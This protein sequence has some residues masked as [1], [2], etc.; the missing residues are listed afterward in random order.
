MDS[1]EHNSEELEVA[2]SDSGATAT[3][4]LGG[5]TMSQT[6]E[7]EPTSLIEEANGKEHGSRKT[8]DLVMPPPVSTSTRAYVATRP[9]SMS[10]G[11][12]TSSPRKTSNG[13]T[14][15]PKKWVVN[16]PP[17]LAGFSSSPSAQSRLSER[18]STRFDSAVLAQLNFGPAIRNEGQ[19]LQGGLAPQKEAENELETTSSPRI[20]LTSSDNELEDTTNG[21]E[22]AQ[23]P[24]PTEQDRELSEPIL[25]DVSTLSTAS[26]T[27]LDGSIQ[28]E[29]LLSP[30]SKPEVPAKSAALLERRKEMQ[31]NKPSSEVSTPTGSLSPSGHKHAP[32]PVPRRKSGYFEKGNFREPG[33]H[34]ES[35][36]SN[37]SADTDPDSTTDRVT[38]NR[39]HRIIELA[40]SEA[41]YVRSLK[42]LIERFLVPM[43]DSLA[44]DS[45]LISAEGSKLICSNIEM[46]YKIH[47]PFA[48]EISKLE[49]DW[50]KDSELGPLMLGLA[51]Y[52]RIYST[53]I[54]KYNKAM[55]VFLEAMKHKS[56]RRFISEGLAGPGAEL[57]DWP[58]YYIQPVQ[59][60]PKYLIILSETLKETPESHPDH[61]KL[62][63]ALDTL[64]SLALVR[65]LAFYQ[66]IL[67]KY[68]ANILLVSSF[69]MLFLSHVQPEN[70][71]LVVEMDYLLGAGIF[72]FFS[73]L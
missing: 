56:F 5:D 38:Q 32:P 53:Y 11:A 2:G 51:P 40:R 39:K 42:Y 70:A 18:L 16:V 49:K 28:S 36:V 23:P 25:R 54:T 9:V 24:T 64:T 41:F 60:I 3:S 43:R 30:R 31:R 1:K 66:T 61:G 50:N 46:I 34:H 26:E 13:S 10:V 44:T 7:D 71:M 20:E 48:A 69:W 72:F 6:S 22:V 73:Y 59:R 27:S 29:P 65:F 62:Q 63:K 37:H 19:A 58:S 35:S 57:L 47:E 4:S 14:G 55:E 45:P 21:S 12:N 8:F 68:H 15:T 33:S 52:L 67:W 17:P